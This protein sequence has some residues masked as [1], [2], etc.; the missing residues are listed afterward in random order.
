[1]V[2]GLL[3]ASSHAPVHGPQLHGPLFIILVAI[4]LVGAV[5]L[6]V[7]R[8]KARRRSVSD[9]DRVST[10]DGDAESGPD[11]DSVSDQDPGTHARSGG[12]SP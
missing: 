11:P 2:H 1:M 5:V 8:A 12:R 7:R 10:P 4:A 3:I 6:L 9:R